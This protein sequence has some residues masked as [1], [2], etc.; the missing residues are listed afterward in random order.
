MRHLATLAFLLTF[1]PAYGEDKPDCDPSSGLAMDAS[2]LEPEPSSGQQSGNRPDLDA[3]RA[4]SASGEPEFKWDATFATPGTSLTIKEK[5]R[6]PPR[7]PSGTM[8]RYEL[9]ATGFSPQERLSLWQRFGAK[10]GELP[11]PVTMSSKGAIQVAGNDLL[12]VDFVPGQA[13]DIALVS[14]TTGKRAH[15]KVIPFP[16]QAK[17]DSGCTISAEVATETGYLFLFSLTGFQ[18]GEEVQTTSRFRDESKTGFGKASERGETSF[19][20]LFEI[21]SFGKATL[22]AAGKN[23]SVSL[24][25]NV[26]KDALVRQ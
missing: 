13:L 12:I 17:G 4:A 18:P 25:Y 23:C 15:A 11:F 10:H 21:G 26:G 22:S 2:C 6:L 3:P 7:K 9:T 5:T 8:I 16:V 14:K 19:P 24:D 1:G 20:V